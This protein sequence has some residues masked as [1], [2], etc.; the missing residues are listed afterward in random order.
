M[1]SVPKSVTCVRLHHRQNVLKL[2]LDGLWTQRE[3]GSGRECL[4]I[5]GKL[6]KQLRELDGLNV[7]L[8][9]HKYCSGHAASMI[10]DSESWTEESVTAGVAVGSWAES[11]IVHDHEGD[12]FG[13]IW[14]VI[15][16]AFVGYF[17]AFSER[18]WGTL[19]VSLQSPYSNLGSHEFWSEV[20]LL[21]PWSRVLLEKLTGKLCS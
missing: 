6:P 4:L 11:Y 20:F 8:C 15:G 2:R 5:V 10:D 19:Q 1:G 14:K 12:E 16:M 7:V 9:G 17:T 3:A 21:T 18:G 13:R